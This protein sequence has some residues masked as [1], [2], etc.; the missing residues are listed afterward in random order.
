MDRLIVIA[1]I[2]F[3]LYRIIVNYNNRKQER[4]KTRNNNNLLKFI[5][6][7]DYQRVESIILKNVDVNYQHPSTGETPLIVAVKKNDAKIVNLLIRN[8]ADV[9][10]SNNNNEN[11]Y[12][13]AV[14]LSNTNDNYQ[15]I[16]NI[17]EATSIVQERIT[18]EKVSQQKL[19]LEKQESAQ[20][21]KDRGLITAC[22]KGDVER[23]KKALSKGANVNAKLTDNYGIEMDTPL[24]IAAENGF[25]DIV[26]LLINE[27][28]KIRIK[29]FGNTALMAAARNGHQNIVDLL[30]AKGA[31][32]NDLTEILIGRFPTIIT[33]LENL[34]I[35]SL[36]IQDK[37]SVS[38]IVEILCQN[39]C[40]DSYDSYRSKNDRL[41]IHLN[42]TS[43]WEPDGIWITSRWLQINKL[44]ENFFSCHEF[45]ESRLD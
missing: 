21:R 8:G 40:E 33:K 15:E 18:K 43:S 29:R 38:D 4:N 24:I 14:K 32:R 41:V 36:E 22:K 42:T 45:S 34:A 44:A 31:N 6:N 5:E 13:L 28:A 30:L 17:F 27:G 11:A 26:E 2:V 35:S 7:G 37:K 9:L 12:D 3:I 25:I 20:E 19:A 1:I 23:V 16:I 39:G 10:A